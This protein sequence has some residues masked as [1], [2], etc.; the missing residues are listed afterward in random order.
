MN[1]CEALDRAREVNS[2][3]ESFYRSVARHSI[4]RSLSALAG[5]AA[6]Q[7]HTLDEELVAL[8]DGLSPEV[9]GGSAPSFETQP[10]PDAKA[11]LETI[12]AWIHVVERGEQSRYSG[13]ADIAGANSDTAI[14]LTAFAEQSRKRADMARGH[15]DLLGL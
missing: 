12:L 4:Q 10:P 2:A 6:E 11:P 7:R 3:L 8:I 9:G 13:L 5:A 15:L 14:R 1:L